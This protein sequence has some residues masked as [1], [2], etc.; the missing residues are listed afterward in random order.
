MRAPT[1]WREIAREFDETFGPGA[2]VREAFQLFG[3]CAAFA[4]LLSIVAAI[5]G[6]S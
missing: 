1:F 5:G 2:T 3:I 6:A 4:I